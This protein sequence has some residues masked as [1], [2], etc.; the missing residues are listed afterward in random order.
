MHRWISSSDRLALRYLR[1]REASKEAGSRGEGSVLIH[2]LS[3]LVTMQKEITRE[4]PDRDLGELSL[5]GESKLQEE[6]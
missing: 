6:L 1:P 4:G 5:P 2:V 3:W